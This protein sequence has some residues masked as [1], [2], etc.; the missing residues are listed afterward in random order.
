MSLYIRYMCLA[1]LTTG[2]GAFGLRMLAAAGLGSITESQ[3]LNLWYASGFVTALLAWAK[4]G[5]PNACEAV[6]G[7]GMALCS[8]GGQVGM[9]LSLSG[10]IPG[11]IVFPLAT[12]GGLLLVVAAGRLLYHEAMGLYG[13]LGILTGVIALIVLAM[14]E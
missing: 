13:K 1:F 6:V 8:L 10:G 7:S 2:L 12:G 5:R 11:F 3:Y 9:A 14:P 4:A